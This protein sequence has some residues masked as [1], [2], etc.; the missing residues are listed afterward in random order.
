MS[1]SRNNL[2][3]RDTLRRSL[4]ASWPRICGRAHQSIT[5]PSLGQAQHFQQWKDST[6]NNISR[7]IVGRRLRLFFLLLVVA[8]A[9]LRRDATKRLT[10][11]IGGSPFSVVFGPKKPKEYFQ[12]NYTLVTEQCKKCRI[13]TRFIVAFFWRHIFWVVQA[14][15]RLR[16]RGIIDTSGYL[17]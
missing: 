16:L 1:V 3:I 5:S 15:R 10:L 13:L 6:S 9:C 11:L 17:L 8:A 7:G 2:L 12:A 14:H 4:G